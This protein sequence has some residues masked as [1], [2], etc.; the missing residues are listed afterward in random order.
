VEQPLA[1]SSQTRLG[2]TTQAPI[3]QAPLLADD[4]A[5]AQLKRG[6]IAAMEG[7]V[8]KYQD[9]LFNAVYRI[10]GNPDDAADLVQ[11]TFVRLLQN[12]QKFEGK[13]ALYTW[14]FRIAVNLALTQRRAGRYRAAVSLDPET[15]PGADLNRQAAPL[16][17]L[18]QDTEIDPGA[19]AALR[20][21]HERALAALGTLEPDFRAVIILRDVEDCDYDQIAAILDV[22]VGTIKSR[23]FR[24]RT[25]LRNALTT[26]PPPTP[27]T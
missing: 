6:N 15:D 27:D 12:V 7:L 22:P 26:P 24:A 21:D 11:E 1:T 5:V 19:A 20:L 10:V 16:R 3:G 9:R 2:A 14:L 8:L 23:L 25:A 4:L 18:A 13:S 17:R